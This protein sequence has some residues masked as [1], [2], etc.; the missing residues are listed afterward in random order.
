[1]KQGR[2]TAAR[3]AVVALALALGAGFAIDAATPAAALAAR[4]AGSQ[5]SAAA[6]SPARKKSY[7]LRQFTGYVTATD[8]TSLTV[9]KRGTKP[10]TMT[11]VKHEEMKTTGEIEKDARVTVYYRDEDGRA[12]AR[13]VVVKTEAADSKTD[14]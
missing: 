8:K 2:M 7:A 4:S 3:L 1:M 12:V 10:R 13:R 6:K 5:K 11:F 9:E 14:R